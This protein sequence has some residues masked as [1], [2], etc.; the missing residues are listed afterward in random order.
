MESNLES[1][2]DSFRQSNIPL[3]ADLNCDAIGAKSDDSQT[4]NRNRRKF[5]GARELFSPSVGIS[6]A[7]RKLFN[8][9]K[10]RE[11][12]KELSKE[13]KAVI[14]AIPKEYVFKSGRVSVSIFYEHLSKIIHA[15]MRIYQQNTL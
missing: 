2:I 12:D 6:P 5:V 7:L 9:A 8:V 10:G 4:R 14:E 3:P 15:V 13:Q 11:L 1:V